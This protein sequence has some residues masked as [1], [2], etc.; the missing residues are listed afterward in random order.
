MIRRNGLWLCWNH[1]CDNTAPTLLQS[2]AAVSAGLE[3]LGRA[4][5]WSHLPLKSPADLCRSLRSSKIWLFC[6]SNLVSSWM[7]LHNCRCFQKD[8]RMLLQ[9]LSAICLA[10]GGPGSIQKDLEAPVVR[11]P[12]GSGEIARCFQTDLHFADVRHNAASSQVNPLSKNFAYSIDIQLLCI[13][14]KGHKTCLL[15]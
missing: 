6:K 10:P 12:G 14:A 15:T 3:V 2:C 11:S 9:S 7:H 4:A 1:C 5:Q 8:P 13:P